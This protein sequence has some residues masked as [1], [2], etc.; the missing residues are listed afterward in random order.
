MEAMGID[1]VQT[2]KNAGLSFKIPA[3]DKAV[4]NGLILIT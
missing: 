4:W 3:K 1:T 2:A